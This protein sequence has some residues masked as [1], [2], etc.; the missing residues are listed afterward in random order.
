MKKIELITYPKSYEDLLQIKDDI[1]G[2]II[3][4]KDLS[5]RV[6]LVIDPDE[7]EKYITFANENNKKIYIALN[8]IIHNEKLHLIEEI[9]QQD[10]IKYVHGVYFGDLSVYQIAEKYKLNEKLIYH[11]E[12]LV[13]NYKIANFWHQKGIMRAVIA[14][15][16]PLEDI[17]QIGRMSDLEIEIMVSGYYP[18][19]HSRR[20]LLTNFF[21]YVDNKDEIDKLGNDNYLIKEE[22]R[23]EFYHI[24]ENENGTHIY[25]PNHLVMIEYLQQFINENISTFRIERQ[26]IEDKDFYQILKAYNKAFEEISVRPESFEINKEK[27]LGEIQRIIPNSNTGFLF[28]K[29]IYKGG[30]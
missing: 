5:L 21:L 12:T 3:G 8:S 26:F 14:K 11:P 2:F 4:I 28:K 17:L 1:T 22:I 7:V 30:K 19:F 25:A 9:L 15:E 13:A 20:N 27:Y 6:P 23:N 24:I 16:L 29:T 10:F 18:M